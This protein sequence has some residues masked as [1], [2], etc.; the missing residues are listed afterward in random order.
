MVLSTD[1]SNKSAI[2]LLDR[3][4]KGEQ[5]TSKER[6][7]VIQEIIALSPRDWSDDPELWMLYQLAMKKAKHDDGQTEVFD[8][9]DHIFCPVHK[10]WY[11]KG[12]KEE[13]DKQRQ[14]MKSM[15]GGL[16]YAA[17]TNVHDCPMCGQDF[18]HSIMSMGRPENHPPRERLGIRL[19]GKGERYITMEKP[20]R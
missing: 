3:I 20:K 6:L 8:P 5:I 16:E 12:Y 9:D 15:G 7:D 14:K 13:A 11:H 2:S 19:M 18:I 1:F 10:I 4:D 17:I